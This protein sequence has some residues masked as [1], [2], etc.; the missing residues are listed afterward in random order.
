MSYGKVDIRFRVFSALH[1][2]STRHRIEKREVYA[3]V[4]FSFVWL[5]SLFLCG[6]DR[7]ADILYLLSGVND[8]KDKKGFGV[9]FDEQA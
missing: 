3:P 4:R 1:S 6:D 5:H 8:G 9:V 2:V 7:L